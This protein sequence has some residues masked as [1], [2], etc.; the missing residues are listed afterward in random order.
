[1]C[2]VYSFCLHKCLCTMCVQCLKKLE[3]GIGSPGTGVIDSCELYCQ[4]WELNLGPLEEQP[5]LLIT[6]PPLW[7]P[8]T[9]FEQSLVIHI[10]FHP[11]TSLI[12]QKIHSSY[13]IQPLPQTC[14][15]FYF[16]LNSFPTIMRF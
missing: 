4:R 3:E 8:S 5:R 10:S 15:A 2:E 14:L 11:S 12:L 1:M 9:F 6:E 7:L 16:S 13:I